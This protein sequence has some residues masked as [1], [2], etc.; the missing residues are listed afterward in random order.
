MTERLSEKWR[1]RAAVL[2]VTPAAAT[3]GACDA[4]DDLDDLADEYDADH[5]GWIACAERMPDLRKM[6][7][8]ARSR[9]S[10]E[11]L[12]VYE[13]RYCIARWYEDG[14]WQLR[15]EDEQILPENVSHWMPLPEPPGNS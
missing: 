2:R 3:N 15:H 13:C 11:V 7:E 1:A 12:M 5:P 9:N 14:Y 4:A 10:K 6:P 8:G